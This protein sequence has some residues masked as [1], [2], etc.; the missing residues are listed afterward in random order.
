ML[1]VLLGWVLSVEIAV[2]LSSCR[3]GPPGPSSYELGARALRDA[4]VV[5]CTTLFAIGGL[6][7]N[8][9]ALAAIRQRA[10]EES[11]PPTLAF[12]GD[13]NF[14]N[15]EPDWWRELNR[16][17]REHPRSVATAGNVEVESASVGEY[18][19]C[20]CG[21]PGYV[22]DG[23]VERSNRIVRRL[24]DAA[25]TAGEAEI[26][27]WLQ[28]LPPALVAEI[29]DDDGAVRARVGI[30]HGDVEGL[31][32][33]QH[34][35]RSNRA[36]RLTYPLTYPPACLPTYTHMQVAAG[37]RSNGAARP[38]PSGRPRLRRS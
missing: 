27:E 15:A 8:D 4:P 26:L 5:R 18:A 14:L 31:A 2:A 12:N 28:S 16:N 20:G 19:G 17:I 11:R 30:V 23:V 35:G 6:Y 34:R 22:S 24:R 13:F 33:C 32:G 1:R 37:G 10:E 36:A 21:Y 29:G 25:V 9:V 38:V 3:A 7:G